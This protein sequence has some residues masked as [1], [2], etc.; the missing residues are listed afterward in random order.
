MKN[1]FVTKKKRSKVF[2]KLSLWT[3]IVALSLV[4]TF[5]I[6]LKTSLK[7][8]IGEEKIENELF[9]LGT[10][11]K[12]FLSFDLLSPKALFKYGLN[13]KIEYEPPITIEDLEMMTKY[14]NPEKPRIYLYSSHDTEEYDSSLGEVYNIKYS[15]TTARY[16]LAERLGN[17][18]IDTY[19]ERE[20]MVTYLRE[21]GLNY[22]HSYYASAHYIEKRLK[23]YPSIELIIDLHRDALPHSASLTYVDGKPCA[24]VIFIVAIEYDGY[25]KNVEWAEKIN[26]H[27][28]AG[29]SRG[30]SKGN[31]YGANG[32]FNQDM[33]SGSLLIEIGGQESTIEEVANTLDYVAKAL[34]ESI[35]E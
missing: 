1:R 18:G 6:L 16:I 35:D 7:G 9:F 24:K 21:N 23:E 2:L 19:V 27:L 29:L 14:K 26:S 5:N 10:N 34:F 32:V 28:P 15:V 33:K 8:L 30:L 20:S 17:L 22:N 11:Q 31:G 3:L 13:Y 25:E 12:K 4:I